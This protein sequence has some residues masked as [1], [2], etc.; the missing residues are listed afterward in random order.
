MSQLFTIPDTI[1]IPHGY[2]LWGKTL[3]VAWTGIE[4]LDCSA[5]SLPNGQLFLMFILAARVI[6]LNARLTDDVRSN[7][8]M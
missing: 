1:N 4:W 5:I 2:V 6:Q 8:K 7:K 3:L